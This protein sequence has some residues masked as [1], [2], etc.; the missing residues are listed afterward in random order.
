MLIW[1]TLADELS[2]NDI[3][4]PSLGVS[5]RSWL[6]G[7]RKAFHSVGPENENG[8]ETNCFLMYTSIWDGPYSLFPKLSFPDWPFLISPSEFV[9]LS[10]TFVISPYWSWHGNPWTRA[11]C[12]IAQNNTEFVERLFVHYSG[13]GLSKTHRNSS[14]T[15][16]GKIYGMYGELPPLR[17]F[18]KRRIGIVQPTCREKNSQWMDT[19][20]LPSGEKLANYH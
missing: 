13:L 3:W 9:T 18:T 12:H 5:W 10:A 14:K 19:W 17:R 7:N 15:A 2:E 16:L 6:S 20:V 11:Q 8:I 4:Y 1:S